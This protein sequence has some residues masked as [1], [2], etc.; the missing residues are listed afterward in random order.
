MAKTKNKRKKPQQP[1]SKEG[2]PNDYMKMYERVVRKH[3]LYLGLEPDFFDKLSKKT[4]MAMTHIKAT[5]PIFT[6]KKG[7]TVPRKYIK[8]LN[9]AM[10][11]YLRN[12]D[13]GEI[14]KGYTC[15]EQFLVGQCFDQNARYLV[16]K[17][18]LPPDQ[19]ELLRIAVKAAQDPK[20]VEIEKDMLVFLRLFVIRLM[21]SCSNINYRYYCYD[22]EQGVNLQK[23]RYA[24]YYHIY[25]QEGEKRT[26]KIDNIYRKAMRVGF[27]MLGVPLVWVNFKRGNIY[28]INSDELL[29]VY[30]Q[31]HALQRMKERMDISSAYRNL[32]FFYTFYKDDN[33]RLESNINGRKMIPVYDHH[34]WKIGYYLFTV[35]DNCVVIKSYV[36][37]SSP[38]TVEGNKFQKALNIQ[39]ED[40]VYWKMDKL[41]FYLETD[42]ERIPILKKALEKADMWHL[43]KLKPT[44]EDFEQHRERK[45]NVL[46]EKFF[47]NHERLNLE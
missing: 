42:L 4:R 5:L 36:P 12:Y 16:E 24:E 19:I 20:I 10:I 17:N 23:A 41:S 30:M 27:V 47:E 18:L 7:H 46:L 8:P 39:K 14:V 26:F 28:G 1:I 13:H 25:S 32:S 3:L 15:E 35:V 29:P 44:D 6:I 43:T 9:E 21:N 2:N 45:A 38:S 34:N 37:L 11:N 22:L 40:I 33:T 31:G